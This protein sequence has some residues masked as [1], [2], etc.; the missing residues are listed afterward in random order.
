MPK[1]KDKQKYT[2]NCPG[3]LLQ[4]ASSEIQDGASKKQIADK[5]K[6]PRSTL[7][8][9]LGF[10]FKEIEPGPYTYLTKEEKTLIDN[11]ICIR[12]KKPAD[13]LNSKPLK[14]SWKKE[15]Y[16][17][18][19]NNPFVEVHSAPTLEKALAP[20]KTNTTCNGF[21][22]NGLQPWNADS[23]DYSECLGKQTEYQIEIVEDSKKKE[24]YKMS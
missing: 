6:I 16:K 4:K 21:R 23:V 3:E 12:V 13:V 24:E 7:Q 20:L 15:I 11:W 9:K 2:E 5:Y 19:R 18:R 8:F 10:S 22:A 14:N 1:V 17:W